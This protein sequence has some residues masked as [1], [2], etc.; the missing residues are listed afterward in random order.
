MEMTE[1]YNGNFYQKDESH[2]SGIL[3]FGQKE[4]YLPLEILLLGL[5]LIGLI[6]V[7]IIIAILG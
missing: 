1:T 5:G 4:F 6:S 2:N 3:C 7:I